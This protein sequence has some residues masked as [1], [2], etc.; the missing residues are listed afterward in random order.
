MEEF[1]A[2]VIGT[3]FAGAVTAC[4]LVQAGQRI[5]V[6]ERGRRYQP[7]DFPS[8]PE[9]V[10]IEKS[11]A[12]IGSEDFTPSPDFDRWFWNIGDGQGLWELRDLEG[13]VSGQAA[14]YGGGSLIYANVHLRAPA[15][16]FTQARNESAAPWPKPYRRGKNR[17][18]PYYDRA[19]YMLDVKP[20]HPKLN[21]AKQQQM[22]RAAQVLG[23]RYE[24][25]AG[26]TQQHRFESIS[27][28]LAIHGYQMP[29]PAREDEPPGPNRFNREQQTC[30]LR[31]FCWM[32]C[33]RQAKNTLDLNYLA[34]MEDEPDDS[35]KETPKPLAEIRTLAEVSKIRHSENG[36]YVVTYLDHLEAQKEVEVTA[37]YVFVCAGTIN[38][39]ELLLR[40]RVP[41]N[42]GKAEE[43]KT[44]EGWLKIETMPGG[45]YFPNVDSL[46]SIHD[47]DETHN[48]HI[49]PTITSALLYDDA[50]DWF[51]VQDGG[52]PAE[53]EP[54]FGLFRSPLWVRRNR[55]L[56]N[57]QAAPDSVQFQDWA[58]H[59]RALRRTRPNSLMELPFGT[60]TEA[61]RK[62][63]GESVSLIP[64]QL[65]KALTGDREEILDQIGN[66]AEDQVR[67]LF[68]ELSG[69]IDQKLD[70][71]VESL[72][73][74]IQVE[75][76]D[77]A[78]FGVSR[79][80]L[81][82]VAQ[83]MFGSESDMARYIAAQLAE[84]LPSDRASLVRS[85]MT[86]LSWVLDYRAS[87]DRLALLLTMGRDR[88]P[89]KL[90]L[91]Q[92]ENRSGSQR[93]VM[94]ARVPGPLVDTT[95][96]TQERALRDIASIAWHGE[97]RT[98]PVWTFLRRR[99]TVHSQ[100][101]C[102]MGNGESAVTRPSGEVRGCD[103]LYVMDA[104][105][106]PTSVGVNPSA[107][108]AAVAEYKIESFIRKHIDEHWEADPDGNVKRW[109]A[110]QPYG[111][112]RIHA[113][114][115]DPLPG[116]ATVHRADNP[117]SKPIGLTFD[118]TMEG[119]HDGKLRESGAA[120]GLWSMEDGTVAGEQILENSDWNPEALKA[121]C[122]KAH[123][124]GIG[125]KS[126]VRVKLTVTIEDLMRF[127]EC[128]DDVSSEYGNRNDQ[129]YE[130][131]HVF[132]G[133]QIPV[134]GSIHINN[135]EGKSSA[136]FELKKG[137]Y[138]WLFPNATGGRKVVNS[139]MRYRLIF[140]AKV[141]EAA[142]EFEFNGV[143]ILD[144][145]AGMDLWQD[146]ATL[147]FEITRSGGEERQLGGVLRLHAEDLLVGQVQS[148]RATGTSDPARQSWAIAA[149]ARFF[150][151][152]L[153][154]IYV[155]ETDRILKVLK[156]MVTRTHV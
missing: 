26:Q 118:E 104:A 94:K 76:E 73:S 95:R 50:E 127:L 75:L 8:F 98:N 85:L 145:Q 150:S 39:T 78:E 41:E 146:T 155:P 15:D 34:V 142:E 79:G 103:G 33:D 70:S 102:A 121:A 113:E 30:D 6:L 134:A 17:L 120:C 115:L 112:G 58:E 69:R 132:K 40:N 53:L 153:T 136:E 137:S 119:F 16:V 47:C 126:S 13:V 81:R 67:A 80:V 90:Y 154:E 138:L 84:D 110:E 23:D 66:L 92:L 19:A 86:L 52:F 100:G 74:T 135:F 38:T 83:V 105:A 43:D 125:D 5:C 25:A 61:L 111:D 56:E 24:S 123:H 140:E 93:S 14:G 96:I 29:G 133:S 72:P 35:S 31:G 10:P 37:P 42:N 62:L 129:G 11:V 107:T 147:Y 1:E 12:D 21:L 44:K 122:D 27:P 91:Q 124:Q 65:K 130:K 143:K 77:I 117:V 9:Q 51:M 3:G 68:D 89:G 131:E 71:L 114:L 149:F 49:G 64:P 97:L 60:V 148:F 109:L 99:F 22:E 87:N 4:R 139:L 54:L 128:Y 88:H 55:F 63:P 108:I 7:G 152:H 46:A 82:L 2:I 151:G 36:G 28:P 59:H 48:A 106:F 144:D 141:G 18:D 116:G 156:N 101:G 32:G 57:D 45:S 20:V